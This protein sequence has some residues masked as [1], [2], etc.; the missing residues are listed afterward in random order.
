MAPVL[1]ATPEGVVA[2]VAALLAARPGRVRL[3]IDGAP[4]ADPGGLADRVASALAPR[5]AVVVHADRFWRPASQRLE[6]GRNEPDAWLDQWLDAAAL[7]REVLDSFVETGRVLPELRDPG[8]DRSSRA[9]ILE[10]PID[11]IVVVCGS[12]LLGRGL[13]FDVAVHIR[14]S[15]GAL[16][17]RTPGD[18]A[19]ILPAL[20]RYAAERDPEGIADLVVRADDPLRPALV[21]RPLPLGRVP[22]GS[23]RTEGP[24]NSRVRP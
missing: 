2:A 4:A 20:A 19:W 13:V 21:A 5:R 24:S 9:P 23:G 17:R 18:Q 8:T 1:P 14:L 12:A 10:L 3:A 22:G 11:A 15:P 16:A 6:R 7:R